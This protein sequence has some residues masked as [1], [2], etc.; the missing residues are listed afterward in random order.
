MMMMKTIQKS[1]PLSE[2]FARC[3]NEMMK[4]FPFY[5]NVIKICIIVLNYVSQFPSS[6]SMNGRLMCLLSQSPEMDNPS[7]TLAMT[8]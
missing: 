5:S 4:T 1:F 3:F 7:S 8:F 2:N 6:I